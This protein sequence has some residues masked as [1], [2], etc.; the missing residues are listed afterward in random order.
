MKL[1]I[2][3]HHRS[4]LLLTFLC[5]WCFTFSITSGISMRYVWYN[6]KTSS[7][8]KDIF[9]SV[10]NWPRLPWLVT[11]LPLF[12]S[13]F[14]WAMD[15]HHPFVKIE[16]RSLRKYPSR[17]TTIA[18][19]RNSHGIALEEMFSF[20]RH[21]TWVFSY[22]KTPFFSMWAV[23]KTP[24]DDTTIWLWLTKAGHGTS[25]KIKGGFVRWEKPPFSM[26]MVT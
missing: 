23:L 16:V 17:A 3:H 21:K 26:A 15:A 2:D 11:V 20:L 6:C 14:F 1:L 4:N 22:T 5:L 13:I 9:Q 12:G 7:A 25:P 10:I 19:Q 18:S 8:A 24:G